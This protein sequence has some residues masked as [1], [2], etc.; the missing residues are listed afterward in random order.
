M[1][2]VLCTVNNCAYWAEGNRCVA[3]T[4]LVIADEAVARMRKDDQEIGEIGQAGQA[5]QLGH[6]PARVSK[7]TC[8]YT[9]RPRESSKA[10]QEPS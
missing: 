9:F 2:E 7:E 8:C 1:P 5:A 10:R 6:T 4:I 3:E